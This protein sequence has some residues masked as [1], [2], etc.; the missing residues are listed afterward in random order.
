MRLTSDE[1][2]AAC[3][4]PLYSMEDEPMNNPKEY[5][6]NLP[7]WPE[8]LKPDHDG[9]ADDDCYLIYCSGVSLLKHGNAGSIKRRAEALELELDNAFSRAHPCCEAAYDVA[10]KVVER[11]LEVTAILP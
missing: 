8:H 3:A 7:K 1:I 4:R 2:H 5:Y 10:F 11:M 6:S 9:S